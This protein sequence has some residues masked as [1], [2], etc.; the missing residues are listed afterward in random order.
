[1]SMWIFLCYNSES[2]DRYFRLF[3]P[4]VGWANGGRPISL[5]ILGAPLCKP[6]N[7]REYALK[8]IFYIFALAEM[9]QNWYF[10]VIS[11][12]TKIGDNASAKH[13]SNETAPVPLLIKRAFSC[14]SGWFGGKYLRLLFKN[15]LF[16]WGKLL[17]WI[18]KAPISASSWVEINQMKAVQEYYVWSNQKEKRLP[19]FVWPK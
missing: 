3:D 10:L 14:R 2:Q 16:M 7:A 17:E 6:R 4:M 15:L 18:Q 13:P 11:I 8:C 5:T 1:M 12:T 19:L 9:G